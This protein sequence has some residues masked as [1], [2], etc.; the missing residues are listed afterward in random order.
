M[1]SLPKTVGPLTLLRHLESDA[2]TE[3]YEGTL[4]TRAGR[5]VI[6]RRVLPHVL[7]DPARLSAMEARV[8]TLMELD[9]P[10][11][12]RTLHWVV[13]GQ[14]R[15]IV[16]D[17]VFGVGLDTVVT[18]CKVGQAP[19]PPNVFLTLATRICNALEAVHAQKLPDGAPLS[20][21]A[22]TPASFTLRHGPKVVLGSFA[23][24]KSS[25]TA[26]GAGSWL[27]YRARYL[28]PEQTHPDHPVG[29]RSDIFSLGACLYEMLTLEPLF[30]GESSVQTVHN[31]RR[32]EVTTQ[33]LRVKEALPGL[34]K[35]L[36]RALSVN[37]RSRY[38]RAFVM[39]EDL[40]GL[41]ANYSFQ[42]IDGTVSTFFEPMLAGL[43]PTGEQMATQPV[44]PA[45]NETSAESMPTWNELG[46]ALGTDR[47][48][49]APDELPND[50]PP[51]PA[52][53]SGEVAATEEASSQPSVAQ[54]EPST[55]EIFEEVDH[56]TDFHAV[57][58]EAPL[59]QPT[60]PSQVG[61]TP[62]TGEHSLESSTEEPPGTEFF[63]IPKATPRPA[64]PPPVAA[65]TITP[66]APSKGTSPAAPSAPPEPSVDWPKRSNAPIFA[67]A[68]VGALGVL[69]VC[70][71]LG[72]QLVGQVI[73]PA[74]GPTSVDQPPSRAATDDPATDDAPAQDPTEQA[75]DEATEAE[76]DDDPADAA[77]KAQADAP[78]PSTTTPKPSADREPAPAV[79]AADPEPS[80][81]PPPAEDV[82]DV[83]DFLA[84]L[85]EPDPAV[86][87]EAPVIEPGDID[88]DA[89]KVQ[90]RQG[91]LT[92]S[93]IM[94]LEMIPADNPEYTRS[95]SLLL[96]DAQSKNDA[97][98]TK[99]YLDDLM[100]K[101]EN[102]YNPVLLTELA[103]YYADQ[104]DYRRAVENARQAERYWARIPSELI[105]TKK[106]EIYEIQA[107]G[108]TGIFYSTENID[109][110]D[111]AID[112]WEKYHRHV[113]KR[114]DPE[115]EDVA[116][117]ELAK[118]HAYRNKLE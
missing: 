57:P 14:E 65:P 66:S 27:Q 104:G 81:D 78:K 23:A 85:G 100:A 37:P 69:L 64:P 13:E 28:S 92:N 118:L 35:V 19:I 83:D 91:S 44:D 16:E 30:A 96:M 62:A 41:M 8:R 49:R 111:R 73:A 93:D 114:A 1:I 109:D 72:Y 60:R 88:L 59:E 42:D 24:G 87:A 36:Y 67:A 71:G 2:L 110:L 70:A 20:H 25:P 5:P 50:L 33:L 76:P 51:D 55:R 29:P 40:R 7:R 48:Q 99:R 84:D 12:Q 89:L 4:D 113:S 94:G 18:W 53:Y 68:G 108:H 11:V 77:P 86:Q 61:G 80:Y 43:E 32:A 38:Q 52:R 107:R 79:A 26:Q 39:R 56:D 74:L 95:R 106:A 54:R 46:P 17:L 97:R 75:A 34:D 82:D 115:R 63:R 105:Y 116:N 47:V 15:Y 31:V 6:I 45:D 10:L 112:V 102:T 90:A 98:A 101:A 9:H 21:M 117:Q 3:V 58:I 103:R 22:I